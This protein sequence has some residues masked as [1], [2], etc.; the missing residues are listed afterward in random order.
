M[1]LTELPGVLSSLSVND[2]ARAFQRFKVIQPFLEDGAPIPKLAKEA[3]LSIRTARRWIKSYRDHGL[4][5]LSKVRRADYGS[6]HIPE[7]V[8]TYV[9]GLALRLPRQSLA[10]IHRNTIKFAQGRDLKAPGYTTVR[11][12]VAALGL[13]LRHLAHEGKKSFTDKYD[14]IYRRTATCPNEIWQAD[15]TQ[16]DV[17]VLDSTGKAFRPWLTVILDDHSRAI[18][19]YLISLDA[20]CALNT[21]LTLHQA[22]WRKAESNWHVC[23]I[24]GRFYTDHGSDFTSIHLEQVAAD[25]KVQLIFSAIGQPRGRGKMERFFGTVNQMFLS[26]LP[27]YT[28]GGGTIVPQLSLVELDQRFKAW[29]LGEYMVNQHGET[30][31]P[32]QERWDKGAFLPRMPASL[33]L[34]DLLLLTVTSSRIVH[35]DGLHFQ[36]CRYMS[37][38]LAAFVRERVTIRYDPRDLAQI[39]VFYQDKFLCVATCAELSGQTVSLKEIIHARNEQRSRLSKELKGKLSVIEEFLAV[40]KTAEPLKVKATPSIPPTTTLKNYE[41]D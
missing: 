31:E 23:G 37:S 20:P 39:R 26:T 17:L 11:K 27:G 3:G 34:L 21:A 22:I 10:S 36:R 30:D 5:G 7:M 16:L 8:R 33:E 41:S 28:A 1:D 6:S 40:H 25:I 35:P 4:A 29:L 19:G 13:P 12:I 14:L 18:C 32:P 2:R 15:H 24:P 9:E 38:T